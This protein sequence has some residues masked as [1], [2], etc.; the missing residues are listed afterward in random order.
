MRKTVC[1]VYDRAIQAF[2]DPF[3]VSHPGLA[4]RGFKDALKNPE[5]QMFHHPEDFVLHAVAMFD[6]ERGTF[7]DSS[8]SVL[9]EGKFVESTND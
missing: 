1:A 2:G 9:A 4:L 5:S 6:V 8:P 3:V 7:D